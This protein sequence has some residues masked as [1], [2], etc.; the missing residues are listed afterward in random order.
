METLEPLE[1]ALMTGE[2]LSSP[3]HSAALLIF[4]PPAEAGPGYVDEIFQDALTTVV[5]LDPRFRRHPHIGVDTAGIWMWRDDE[6][7]DMRDHVQ[8]RTLPPGDRNALWKL[9]SELHGEPLDRSRAMWMFYLIDGLDD[10]RFAFYIKTHHTVMDGIA[11]MRMLATALTTDPDRRSMRPFYATEPPEPAEQAAASRGLVRNPVSLMRSVLDTAASGVDLVR[12]LT[13]GNLSTLVGSIAE[14]AAVLPFGA[15]YT[16]FNGRLARERV[17]A[18][19]SW[20]R[21]RI[22][23][24]Q[25]LAGVTGNDVV[26]AVIAGVL[27]DWLIAHDELPKRSLV[28]LCPITVR[29]REQVAEEDVHA[30][31]FGL[32]L[33][34]LGT[35]L[36][37]PAE[38]LAHIHQTM[39][40]AKDQVRTRG[41]NAANL[42]LAPSMGVTEV[43]LPM[44][45]L[46]PRVRTGF[47]LAISNVPG[48]Q[49][50]MY[51]NGARLEEVYPVSTVYDGLAL[52]AT[53]FS[54]AD[55]ATF[56]YVSGQNVIPD[57]ESF[58]QLTERALVEL[59]TAV[60]VAP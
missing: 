27:R 2:L 28:G 19:G 54:Y 13:P 31:L 58:I 47:N 4:S 12:K 57:I 5:D 32:G 14:A 21:S 3:L 53:V 59:E 48:P 1:A 49:T 10:G 56:G 26:T 37:D 52:N 18:G 36:K 29:S 9:I 35:D 38:R 60:G 45:P 33:C 42:L 16:R 20:P 23:A 8:R 30:N 11:G 15:P 22:R 51:W 41:A 50:H 24:V 46:A 40:V 7:I 39:A 6:N 25:N 55:C 34:P 43:L 17:A 44:V